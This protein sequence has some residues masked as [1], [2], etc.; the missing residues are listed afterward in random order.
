MF[1]SCLGFLAAWV[2]IA[3]NEPCSLLALQDES[4]SDVSSPAEIQEI[5]DRESASR[6]ADETSPYLLMRANDEIHWYPWGDAAVSAANSQNKL[7]FLVVGAHSCYSTW[8]MHQRVLSDKAVV[9]LLNDRFICVLVDRESRPDLAIA[10]TAVKNG[11]NQT[12]SGVTGDRTGWPLTIF[13]TPE[14]RPFFGATSVPL[15]DNEQG[16]RAGLLSIVRTI[17]KMW[18]ENPDSIREGAEKVS[19]VANTI[20]RIRRS[21]DDEPVDNRVVDLVRSQLHRRFDPIYGGFDFDPRDDQRPKH[22]MAPRLFFLLRQLEEHA[23]RGSQ[24]VVE[25]ILTLTLDKM[26]IGALR[27]HVDG[28]FHRYSINRSWSIPDF[29]KTLYDNAQL[30]LIFARASKVLDRDDYRAMAK[31]TCDFLLNNL[32]SPEGAF[33]ASISFGSPTEEGE[34]ENGAYY[35]WSPDQIKSAL[36]PEQFRRAEQL[37]GLAGKPNYGDRDYVLYLTQALNEY[38]NV[39]G[40]ESSVLDM[41]YKSILE[42]LR[43]ARSLRPQ[44]PVDKTIVAA[45]NGLML[46]SLV[47]SG[48][49]LNE[50]EYLNAAEKLGEYIWNE[51]QAQNG[52]L[53]RILNRGVNSSDVYVDDYVFVVD[54][55][56]AY[57]QASGNELWLDRAKKLQ[58]LQERHFWSEE[59]GGYYYSIADLDPIV[60]RFRTIADQE[61]P[62][63]NAMGVSN[64]M[65]L[66]DATGEDR[67][68]T[69]AKR[70]AR[71]CNGVLLTSP[72]SAV[73]LLVWLERLSD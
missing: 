15:H 19:A 34:F 3:A 9:K 45:W 55:F 26:S 57:Y 25:Q 66:F 36:T 68:L 63:S 22:I 31:Q 38:A 33:Y 13:M 37:F 23:N 71:S 49:L 50:A 10:F 65:H 70:V 8:N 32:R 53:R 40:V 4:V 54:G 69:R 14:S 28:G 6:L 51:T 46:R 67:Y 27:D 47:E 43:S 58:E 62:S 1:N 72:I 29:E 39:L 2:I 20:L 42:R 64:L 11:Y 73:S 41:E 5:A 17:D 18:S 16:F 48:T 44:P 52:R 59:R 7:I 56:L 35:R 60:N 12:Y 30:A 24:S 61:L 21:G